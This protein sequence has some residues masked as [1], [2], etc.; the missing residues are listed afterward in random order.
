MSMKNSNDTIGKLIRDI[1]TCSAVPQPTAPP[2]AC[3]L[4]ITVCKVSSEFSF[5]FTGY[6]VLMWSTWFKYEGKNSLSYIGVGRERH[7]EAEICPPLLLE[8]ATDTNRRLRWESKQRIRTSHLNLH[9][10]GMENVKSRWMAQGFRPLYF[11]F[12]PLYFGSFIELTKANFYTVKTSRHSSAN[13]DRLIFAY[14]S[15]LLYFPW[16]Q[17]NFSGAENT[18]WKY[19]T[20]ILCHDEICFFFRF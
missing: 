12:R 11:G 4:F 9:W 7:K 10:G 1:P 13:S 19:F 17:L 6:N 5:S 2:A 3:L 8:V 20:E 16:T 18:F 14:L 15:L